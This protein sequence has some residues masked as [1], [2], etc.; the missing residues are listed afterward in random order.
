MSFGSHTS[1][2]D[3]PGAL[4]D[5]WN[6]MC[7]HYLPHRNALIGA[8][9]DR[10]RRRDGQRLHILDIGGG[11]GG[12]APHLLASAPDV[13]YLVA[14][15]DPLLLHLAQRGAPWVETLQLDIGHGTWIDR[16]TGRTFDVAL[17]ALVL[18]HLEFDRQVELLTEIRSI[19]APEGEVIILEVFEPASDLTTADLD[20]WNEWWNAASRCTDPTIRSLMQTRPEVASAEH[21]VDLATQRDMLEAAGFTSIET[22]AQ[23]GHS[24]AIAAS[25]PGRH[26][27]WR[28]PDARELGPSD[29]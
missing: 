22:I 18:H 23:H 6:A 19:L 25:M 1:T 28:D 27:V 9:A 16:L 5:R 24:A 14:D 2:P 8:V 17:L 13:R 3:D 29:P 4:V 10:L 12:F 21:H 15:I 20:V 7:E 11:P 26:R